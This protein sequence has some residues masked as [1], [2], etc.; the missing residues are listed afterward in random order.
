MIL[1]L[2]VLLFILLLLIGGDKGATCLLSLLGNLF[3][4]AIIIIA[5][6][7]GWPPLLVTLIG[8][9][10]ISA[11]TLFYQNGNNEKTRIAFFA[12][13]LVMLCFS[14]FIFFT[15]YSTASMGLNE[16]QMKEES[17]Q[18]YFHTDI[19][20]SMLSV[21]ISMTLLS[22][23]GAVLDT[24]LS[25]TSALWEV[26]KH[27][28]KLCPKEVMSSAFSIG[29]DII[30]TTV[31]TLLFAYLGESFLLFSYI[32]M[33]G[34]SLEMLFNSKLLFQNLSIMIFGAIFCLLAV[35]A[36]AFLTAYQAPLK[37]R[38]KVLKDRLFHRKD[39]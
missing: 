34:L 30:G 5:M 37:R 32:R 21:F 20:I 31:N 8:G 15:V 19:G 26:K 13:L 23:L 36:S 16:V 6:A 7:R 39:L 14:V 9:L 2:S 27:N 3:V 4:L 25:I 1:F 29:R 33:E 22:C 17:I 18:F 24:A 28:P 10:F 12:S 35:P 11:F 38:A